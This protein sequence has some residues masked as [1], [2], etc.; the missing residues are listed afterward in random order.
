MKHIIHISNL[1][2]GDEPAGESG[3]QAEQIFDGPNRTVL[4]IKMSAG[5][6]LKRHKAAVP[7]TVLCLAGDGTFR[8][9]AD[10]EDSQELI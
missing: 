6:I 4:H 3:L 2:F 10:L 5:A 9:G 7:I 8:A 1:V